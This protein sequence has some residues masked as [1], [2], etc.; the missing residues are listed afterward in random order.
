MAEIISVE[1]AVK[2]VKKGATIGTSGFLGVCHPRLL[3]EELLRVGTDELTLIQPV[4]GFPGEEHDVGKLAENHQ[5]KKFVGSH[6]GTSPSFNNQYLSGELEVDYVPM[7]TIVEMIR[8][9][10]AGLGAV[11]TP[12]GVGTDQEK[13][14]EKIT[15][16]GKEYLIYDPV[17]YDVVFVKANKADKYGNLVNDLTSKSI[18]KELALASKIVIAE[19]DEIVEVGEIDPS[20]VHVPGILVDYIVQGDKP[21]QRHA[22]YEDLWGRNRMLQKEDK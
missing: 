1:E 5:I 2:F 17:N 21:E 6:T 13:K 22:Y 8:A 11:V 20:D 10:G 16:N 18:V 19:V 15:R 14:Q 4:T 7:G 3:I 12:T 9:G